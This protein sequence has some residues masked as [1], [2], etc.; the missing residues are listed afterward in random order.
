MTDTDLDPV[1]PTRMPAT[2][3]GWPWWMLGLAIATV[4]A[5]IAV[6]FAA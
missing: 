4:A 3:N 6:R 5:S 1:P 2:L